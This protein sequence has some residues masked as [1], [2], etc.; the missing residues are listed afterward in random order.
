MSKQKSLVFNGNE[1]QQLIE[2]YLNGNMSAENVK[3]VSGLLDK[4]S[5]RKLNEEKMA[6]LRLKETKDV[7]PQSIIAQQVKSLMGG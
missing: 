1:E 4:Q 7:T 5:K 2:A 6:L 3:V